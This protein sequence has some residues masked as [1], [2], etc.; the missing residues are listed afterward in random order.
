MFTSWKWSVVLAHSGIKRIIDIS[1]SKKNVAFP[2]RGA[3]TAG[4]SRSAHFFLMVLTQIN[5]P[6][7][8][9]LACEFNATKNHKPFE[10]DLTAV[11]KGSSTCISART[12]TLPFVRIWLRVFPVTCHFIISSATLTDLTNCY[13]RTFHTEITKLHPVVKATY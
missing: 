10:D 7:S 11:C 12:G 6:Q 3:L 2:W 9:V 13:Q 5:A 8:L 4:H 1:C